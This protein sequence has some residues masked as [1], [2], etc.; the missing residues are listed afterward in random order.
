MTLTLVRRY[1]WLLFSDDPE[2]LPLTEYVFNTEAHPL[3]IVGSAADAALRGAYIHFGTDSELP[4]ALRPESGERP[5]RDTSAGDEP[6]AAD[7]G[8]WQGAQAQR[9]GAGPGDGAQCRSSVSEPCDDLSNMASAECRGGS[10]CSTSG[11]GEDTSCLAAGAPTDSHTAQAGTPASP[12][13]SLL[14]HM[15]WWSARR[16]GPNSAVP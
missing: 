10:D 7:G 13:N 16:Y 15:M 4:S 14:H 5:P 9:E 6:V 1:L 12:F 2:L 8:G 3:P 11:N